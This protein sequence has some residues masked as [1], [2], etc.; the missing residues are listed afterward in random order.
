MRNVWQNK[1]LACPSNSFKHTSP[2]L[3][4]PRNLTVHAAGKSKYGTRGSQQGCKTDHHNAYGAKRALGLKPASDELACTHFEGCPGCSL[5]QQLHDPPIVSKAQA[6]FASRGF[7]DF[8]RVPGPVQGW[9]CRAK[10]AVR[11]S[12]A[13]PELGLFQLGSHSVVAIPECR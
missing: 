10:L 8:R 12:S 11:G 4:R 7:A 6:F 2:H 5:Q 1:S 3:Q 13:A 9:R